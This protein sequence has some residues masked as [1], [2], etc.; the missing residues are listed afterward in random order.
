[1]WAFLWLSLE[2]L[3]HGL[4]PEASFENATYILT[5][6]LMVSDYLNFCLILV[7]LDDLFSLGSFL[8]KA[9]MKF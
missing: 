5:L 9:R 1:M 7:T 6:L 3:G 8:C 4:D 2:S